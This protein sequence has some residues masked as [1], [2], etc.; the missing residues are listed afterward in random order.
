MD[1]L[2]PFRKPG[3]EVHDLRDHA[4]DHLS[5]I[6]KTME[7]AGEFTAVPGWGLVAVGLSA[8][9]SAVFA[10]GLKGSEW[11]NV[12]LVEAV[13]AGLIA[14]WSI[15]RKSRRAEQLWFVGPGRRALLCFTPTVA[16]AAILTVWFVSMDIYAPLPGVWL[17][18]YGAALL[19]AGTYSVRPVPVS[20]AVFMLLGLVTLFLPAGMARAAMIFGFG[21][22][23]VLFGLWIARRYG[24]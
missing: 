10:H 11:L 14:G 15:D 18:L 23:H 16:V 7:G 24:G 20:G 22:V 5:Y 21:G 2:T 8:L 13:I 17:S 19:A 12:W 9:V 1:N 6:R 4:L 3:A